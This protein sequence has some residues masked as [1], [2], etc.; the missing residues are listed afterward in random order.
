MMMLFISYLGMVITLDWRINQFG[1]NCAG[2]ASCYSVI[3]YTVEKIEMP[4]FDGEI[5]DA[6]RLTLG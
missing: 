6:I 2:V 4:I 1:T 5:F 3:Q